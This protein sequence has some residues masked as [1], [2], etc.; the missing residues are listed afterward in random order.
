MTKVCVMQADDRPN[1]DYL[2]LTTNINKEFCKIL[3]YEYVFIPIK[4]D[5]Y[6][7]LHPATK[8]IHIVNNFLETSTYDIIIFLD[9][10]AWI[11]NGCWL[12]DII[13]QLSQDTLKQG[14]FSRDPYVLKNTYINTGSFIIKNN[15]YVKEMYSNIITQLNNNPVY[16]NRWQYDQFYIS[17]FVFENKEDFNIFVPDIINTPIGKVLRHNWKKDEKMRID[18]K[19]LLTNIDSLLIEQETFDFNKYYDSQPF[20]NT[21]INGYEYFE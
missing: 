6:T 17:N 3:G 9:S 13:D 4:N 20:P 5:E 19:L 21:Q 10:D 7:H 18:I 16:H 12:K 2:L 1:L 8:K 11:Q 14:C 15:D